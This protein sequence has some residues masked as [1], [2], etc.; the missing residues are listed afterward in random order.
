MYEN[1][2]PF[3]T[4]SFQLVHTE[5]TETAYSF[6]IQSIAHSATC[7]NCHAVSSHRHSRTNRTIQDLPM[8]E[9]KV[10]YFL[11]LQKWFCQQSTCSVRIFTERIPQANAYQR[12][13]TRCTTVLRNIAFATNCVEAAKLSE[14]L[15]IPVSH[16]TL[17]RIIYET[18]QPQETSP[19]PCPR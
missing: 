7:P 9:K 16:D 10:Y 2:L 3:S 6:Y 12:R 8:N 11:Q 13:T 19:F 18:E 17:L 5:Q 15:H 1:L 4:T 14:S